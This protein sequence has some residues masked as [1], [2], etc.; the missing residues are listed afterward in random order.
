MRT[1]GDALQDRHNHF[2]LC[3]LLG[4]LYIAFAHSVLISGLEPYYLEHNPRYLHLLA[5]I[6][7]NALRLF[8]VFSGVLV[9]MSL[10]TRRSLSGYA[11][12]RILRIF[13]PLLLVCAVTV[14]VLGPLTTERPLTAYFADIRTWAY[15]PLAGSGLFVPDLPGV[16]E[17]VPWATRINPPLWTLRY[18][19]IFYVLLVLAS[20]A[21]LLSRARL[22]LLLAATLAVYLLLTFGTTL[23]GDEFIDSMTRFGMSFML[24]VGI[25]HYR[26]AIPV[27]IWWV[28][29]FGLATLLARNTLWVE[30]F[31]TFAATALVFW[32]GLGVKGPLLR[33]NGVGELSY[34]VYIWHW[35]VGQTLIGLFPQLHAWQLFLL[36]APCAVTIAFVSWRFVELPALRRVPQLAAWL[37]RLAHRRP[38]LPAAVRQS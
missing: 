19:I 31:S 23:R 1:V 33:Y 34:S 7:H 9:A 2:N 29:P 37:R 22:P 25:Y 20:L 3:R 30:L 12:A 4:A 13:P 16:F 5:F 21:G 14:F 38:I 6:G 11:A 32:V 10:D 28:V 8:F 24:G 27:T 15:L 26:H 36:I 17:S 18:E 35:P